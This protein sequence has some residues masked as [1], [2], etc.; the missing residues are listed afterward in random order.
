[1]GAT[2]NTPAIA[3]IKP[4]SDATNRAGR[5]LHVFVVTPLGKDGRGGIDRLMDELRVI[6][7]DGSYSDIDVLFSTSRGPGSIALSPFYL[8]GSILALVRRKIAGRIDVAHINLSQDGSA[9]RKIVVAEACRRLRI[10]YVLHLHGSH[11]HHFWDGASPWFDRILTRLF[12]DSARTLVLGTVWAKYIA[13]KAPA[14]APRIEIFPTATRD[15]VI[16]RPKT[17]S[18]PVSIFFSGRHGA[19]KGVWE[20]TAALGKLAG[21]PNWRATLTGDGEFEKTRKL[22]DELGIANVVSIP[23]WIDANAFEN[24]LNQ[25]DILALP[26]LDENLPLSVVEAFARGIAV[27]CTPV[28]AL[29]DIVKHEETGLFVEP[30]DID[31]LAASLDRLIR[32]PLLRE[33]LAR[34]GRDVYEERLNL[35]TYAKRLVETWRSAAET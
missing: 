13:S 24:L 29:P 31:G 9:Y 19:R 1:M 7:G 18:G 26:S 6:L 30:G 10:P 32:D 8:L 33:R 5:P 27:V 3:P 35:A 12:S 2:V 25:A 34:N 23:G 14:A 17:K 4:A 21:D 16:D 28:G 11:F 15:V 22:V 20:L